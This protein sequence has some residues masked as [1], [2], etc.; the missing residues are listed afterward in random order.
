LSIAQVSD[1]N[2]ASDIVYSIKIVNSTGTIVKTVTTTQQ[3]WQ[4]DISGFTPGIY[5][6]QV[7]NNKNKS[8]IGRSSFVKM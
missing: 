2:A 8:E 3:K 4:A 6:I 7:I 5:F 1:S